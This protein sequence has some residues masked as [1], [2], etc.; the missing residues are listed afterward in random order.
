MFDLVLQSHPDREFR[1]R[2]KLQPDMEKLNL[3]LRI[4]EPEGA[5]RGKNCTSPIHVF[6]TLC[7]AMQLVLHICEGS[8]ALDC[9]PS[10]AAGIHAHFGLIRPCMD[11]M[12]LPAV[13]CCQYS[14]T[15]WFHRCL[16]G[17]AKTVEFDFDLGADTAMSV[18]SEMVEDLSLSAED[19]RAIAAAIR[20]EIKLL[21]GLL[22]RRGD[23]SLA[24]SSA[25]VRTDPNNANLHAAEGLQ[26]YNSTTLNR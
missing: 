12:K 20:N 24:S 7:A 26:P 17:P 15:I 6:E 5:S 1:V 2:G 14:C 8:I 25:G 3:R 4:S 18:A 10:L 11:R 16:A 19:A 23:D 13:F 21:T 9:L 22:N